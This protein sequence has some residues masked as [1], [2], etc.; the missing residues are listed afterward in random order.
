M[1]WEGTTGV[2]SRIA[3]RGITAPTRPLGQFAMR[4]FIAQQGVAGNGRRLSHAP[5]VAIALSLGSGVRGFATTREQQHHLGSAE[6]GCGRL[7]PLDRRW[8]ARPVTFARL[9]R[10]RNWN[11]QTTNSAVPSPARRIVATGPFARV[12]GCAEITAFGLRVLP[13]ERLEGGRLEAV[14]GVSCGVLLGR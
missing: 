8:F 10:W 14:E 7:L 11:A 3:P 12:R 5:P 6:E 4:G 13:G 2:W 9:G 1:R